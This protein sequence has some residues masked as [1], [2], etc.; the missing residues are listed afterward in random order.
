[1]KL[2]AKRSKPRKDHQVANSLREIRP[3]DPLPAHMIRVRVGLLFEVR[4]TG[5]GVLAAA[6]IA[7]LSIAGGIW[8]PRVQRGARSQKPPRSVETQREDALLNLELDPANKDTP[9]RPN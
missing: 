8:G 3:D 5:W 6:C 7:L 9:V 2:Q 1:M 4:V